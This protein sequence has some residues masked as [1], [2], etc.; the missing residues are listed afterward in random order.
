MKFILESVLLEGQ[1]VFLA[2]VV[3]TDLEKYHRT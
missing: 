1:D 3:H 2:N